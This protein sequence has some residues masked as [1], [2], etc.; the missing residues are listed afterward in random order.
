MEIYSLLKN[1]LNNNEKLLKSILSS[2]KEQFSSNEKSINI[3]IGIV[4]EIRNICLTLDSDIYILDNEFYNLITPIKTYSKNLFNNYKLVNSYKLYDALKI[5]VVN[6]KNF[7]NKVGK[8]PC[9][10]KI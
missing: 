7:L 5:D 8:W 9:I 1:T 6:L 2:T 4:N 3:G 10:Q